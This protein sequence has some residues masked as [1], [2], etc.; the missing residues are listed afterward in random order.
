MCNDQQNLISVQPHVD[1]RIETWKLKPLTICLPGPDG[2][3]NRADILRMTDDR[4]LV[5]HVPFIHRV[6]KCTISISQLR[7]RT[8]ISSLYIRIL[9]DSRLQMV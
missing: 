2:T 1:K 4:T 6:N 7:L 3:I 9:Q 8:I 5:T